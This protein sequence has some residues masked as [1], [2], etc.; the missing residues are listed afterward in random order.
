MMRWVYEST[1][2]PPKRRNKQHP[3]WLLTF[4][5]FLSGAKFSKKTALVN[6]TYL[7]TLLSE[8]NLHQLHSTNLLAERGLRTSHTSPL[9]NEYLCRLHFY[10]PVDS[11]PAGWTTSQIWHSCLIQ[12]WSQWLAA[13][14]TGRGSLLNRPSCP[15]DYPIGQGTEP[16]NKTVDFSIEALWTVISHALSRPEVSHTSWL[17]GYQKPFFFLICLWCHFLQT[18]TVTCVL[19]LTST[20]TATPRASA[21]K[22][23]WVLVKA[24]ISQHIVEEANY[25]RRRRRRRGGRDRQID[26]QT[27][28]QTET[29]RRRQRERQ[30]RRQRQR[31][32]E[33]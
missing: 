13:E 5:S 4:S 12:K 16:T 17:F 11:S 33:T 26:G 3:A 8:R 27:E 9:A 10:F 21:T 32:S 23:K 2:Q 20:A 24:I 19:M 15:T 22:D 30:S 18:C 31:D 14:K 6:S 1:S 28:K 7:L 29:E 25:D